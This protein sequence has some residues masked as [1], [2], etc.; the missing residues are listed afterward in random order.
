MN[1]NFPL[2]L[3]NK[4]IIGYYHLAMFTIKGLKSK[5]LYCGMPFFLWM[6]PSRAAGFSNDELYIWGCLPA[7]SSVG[8]WKA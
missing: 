6:E 3:F 7:A 1:S 5:R 2:Y 8:F 4:Y